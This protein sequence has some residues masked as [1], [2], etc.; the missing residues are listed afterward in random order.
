MDG[1][2]GGNRRNGG[3]GGG[4]EGR[5]EEGR[6][7]DAEKER[8]NVVG[9]G[10]GGQ[11][12]KRKEKNEAL[13]EKM[14]EWRAEGKSST[15]DLLPGTVVHFNAFNRQCRCVIDTHNQEHHSVIKVV[16]CMASREGSA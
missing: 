9:T 11:Q 14:D 2:R 15:K 13:K 12:G 10:G 4:E 16:Y 8:V 3:G 5:K 1:E 7:G 6:R